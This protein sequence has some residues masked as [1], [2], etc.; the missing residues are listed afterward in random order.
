MKKAL[1]LILIG[2]ILLVLPAAFVI[3][4]D[5]AHD[6][7]RCISTFEGQNSLV[8]RTGGSSTLSNTFLGLSFLGLLLIIAAST[9]VFSK[10]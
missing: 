2:T 6:T 7:A 3:Y 5:N 1:M 9:H 8:C 10:E 4:S